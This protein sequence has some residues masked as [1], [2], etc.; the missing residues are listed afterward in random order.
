MVKRDRRD[1]AVLRQRN[2]GLGGDLGL[3]GGGVDHENQ[4]FACAVTQIDRRPHGAQVMRAWAGGHDDQLG[5][6]NHALDRHGDS[7]RR[8]DHREPET[9][10]AQ[11]GQ[12]GR[13]AGDG[14]LGKSGQFR[15]ALVPPVGQRSLRVDVDKHDRT[16][17][18]PLCL[19]GEMPGQCRL[20]R[21][22][23]L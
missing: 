11:D 4:W 18:G 9:L 1:G 16:G 13:Q 14:G 20:A 17:A 7:G 8:V 23:L 6:G 2:G 22:T 12:I 15:L 10:L 5:N 21:S 3:G 19:H